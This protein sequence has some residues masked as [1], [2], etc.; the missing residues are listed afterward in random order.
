MSLKV[1]FSFPGVRTIDIILLSKW[2]QILGAL[3]LTAVLTPCMVILFLYS[4]NI[5]DSDKPI[6]RTCNLSPS[7]RIPCGPPGPLTEDYCEN[8]L[9]CCFK[10]DSCFH[11]YPSTYYYTKEGEKYKSEQSKTPIGNPSIKNLGVHIQ[12][13]S[14]NQLYFTLYNTDELKIENELLTNHKE[15]NYTVTEQLG[16]VVSRSNQTIFSTIRG[17]LIASNGYWEITLDVSKHIFGLGELYLK[18]RMK[19]VFYNNRDDVN[20]LPIIMGTNGGKFHGILIETSGLLE[21]EVMDSNLL[22]L[23]CITSSS[24]GFTFKIVVGERPD[25]VGRELRV[26]QM[27]NVKEL[28]V[29]PAWLLGVHICR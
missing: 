22:L 18:P 4:T 8:T 6:P 12:E 25:D 16:I 7:H 26:M 20:R 28:W 2:T 5:P 1:L 14:K 23:K 29:P 3:L 9:S 10:S 11:S 21:I 19:Y 27:G 17:P 24:I 13:V 15:Y